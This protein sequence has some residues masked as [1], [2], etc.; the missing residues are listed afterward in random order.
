MLG[1]ISKLYYR[2]PSMARYVMLR[3]I[4]TTLIV[5]TVMATLFTILQYAPKA[6]V[7]NIKMTEQ[8]CHEMKVQKGYYITAGERFTKFF[9][10]DVFD[11]LGEPDTETKK[12]AKNWDTIAPRLMVSISLGILPL[13]VGTL[14]GILG[15][16]IAAIKRNKF[17]DRAINFI[18]VVCSC[19]PSV[20][21]AYLLQIL[22]AQQLGWFPP[23]ASKYMWYESGKDFVSYVLPMIAMMMFWIVPTVTRYIRTDLIEV[24]NSDYILLARAKGL[25]YR[26]VILKHGLRNSL[27]PLLTIFGPLAISILT[28]TFIIES[29]FNI[30]GLGR[31]TLSA[32]SKMDISMQ[33]ATTFL[34]III[35]SL[36]L[37]AVDILY[38]IVDPRIRISGG[39]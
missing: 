2:I 17:S 16:V 13:I 28:G 15:G 23:T 34:F 38:G 36:T 10:K 37:F 11:G 9:T 25:S 6:E 18:I 8:R 35:G 39:E 31:L 3:L 14:T 30:D 33:A 26:K 12:G 24:L 7:C 27:I 32:I 22:F 21:L 20:I 19:L 1:K 4:R 29:V 5:V